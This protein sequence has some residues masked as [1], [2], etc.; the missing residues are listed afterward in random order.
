MAQIKVVTTFFGRSRYR[1]AELTRSLIS[2][3]LMYRDK[4]LVTIVTDQ[5]SY[6][7]SCHGQ[8]IGLYPIIVTD[9]AFIERTGLEGFICFYF[10]SDNPEKSWFE[11]RT[12]TAVELPVLKDQGL[13]FNSKIYGPRWTYPKLDYMHEYISQ[14]TGVQPV[15]H[16][17]VV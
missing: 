3:K 15:C 16:P 10:G 8:M 6:I 2:L 14:K 4:I 17:F 5:R 11:M 1:E 7:D 9:R 13:G 12:G